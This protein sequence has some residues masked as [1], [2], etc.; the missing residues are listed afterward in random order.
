MNRSTLLALC[1]LCVLIGLVLYVM[2]ETFSLY[3]AFWW[4]DVLVH[5]FIG[6][7]GGLG[8]YWGLFYSG[9]FFKGELESRAHAVVWTLFC[10]MLWGGAWEYFEYF[11]AITD[12]HEGYLLDTINDLVLDG[13]GGALGALLASYKR[14]DG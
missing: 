13:C 4:Y 14:K 11:F 6:F 3:W 12:S 2:A 8:L 9:L 10:V 7:T 1:S 5:F